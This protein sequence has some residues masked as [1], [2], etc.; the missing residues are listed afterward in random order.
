MDQNTTCST[1]FCAAAS[2]KLCGTMCWSTL[3][4]VVCEAATGPAPVALPSA[5]PT[6]G[7][8]TFTVT[9]PTTSASVVTTSK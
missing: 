6:P 1:S 5:T 3:A 2:K 4:R 8:T 7:C 9:S